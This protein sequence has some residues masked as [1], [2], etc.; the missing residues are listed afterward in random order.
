MSYHQYAATRAYHEARENR[1]N[2]GQ[3]FCDEVGWKI[4]M[5]NAYREVQR[6]D[7]VTF[8]NGSVYRTI[9]DVFHVWYKNTRTNEHVLVEFNGENSRTVKRHVR[10]TESPGCRFNTVNLNINP[11]NYSDITYFG[12]NQAVAE[13]LGRLV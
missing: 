8:M 4:T 5:N 13:Y 9:T 6:P 10:V 12:S 11:N 3:R 1:K 7:R 2:P